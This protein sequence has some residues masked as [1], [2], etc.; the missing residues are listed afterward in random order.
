MV[1][2]DFTQCDARNNM[3]TAPVVFYTPEDMTEI[4][5]EKLQAGM[6]NSI[7]IGAYWLLN[8]VAPVVFYYAWRVTD[9]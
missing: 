5:E 9:I 4:T 2:V 3:C 6:I 8:A 1:D 7:I